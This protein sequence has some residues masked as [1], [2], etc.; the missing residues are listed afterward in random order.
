M[1]NNEFNPLVC[2]ECNF[3]KTPLNILEC[4]HVIC[5]D[6]QFKKKGRMFLIS[7][8][9]CSQITSLPL[10]ESLKSLALLVTREDLPLSSR[11]N[12]PSLLK[13]ISK[14]SE[15]VAMNETEKCELENEQE[16]L[17]VSYRLKLEDINLE[18]ERKL[19]LLEQERDTQITDLEKNNTLKQGNL[20]KQVENVNKSISKTIQRRNFL[21][22]C[23]NRL[24]ESEYNLYKSVLEPTKPKPRVASVSVKSLDPEPAPPLIVSKQQQFTQSLPLFNK[25]TV[26][27]KPKPKPRYTRNFSLCKDPSFSFGRY[28][29]GCME[30]RGL[31]AVCVSPDDS[32][33]FVLDQNQMKVF[34]RKGSFIFQ[35]TSFPTKRSNSLELAAIAADEINVYVTSSS[36][37][38]VYVI[39]LTYSVATDLQPSGSDL[40]TFI[41]ATGPVIQ[42]LNRP[43]PV[44]YNKFKS[45]LYIADNGNKRVVVYNAGLHYVCQIGKG[46]IELIGSLAVSADGELIYVLERGKI[47]NKCVRVFGYSGDLVKEFA[48]RHSELKHPWCLCV[49]DEGQVMISDGSP[50]Y[51]TLGHSVR[52]FSKEGKQTGKIGCSGKGMGQFKDPR[53]LVIDSKGNL[54]VIDSGNHRLQIF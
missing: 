7:C 17:A 47:S 36:H 29:T 37:D 20:S 46:Q 4:F 25:D 18:F 16:S 10:K 21:Q 34:D 45:L 30:F 39:S 33:V 41:G 35:F 11:G 13:N 53:G 32:C 40:K 19:R 27:A 50:D 54:I 43:G 8:P 12:I 26:P 31:K 28:G 23:S 14:L 42:R 52:V 2:V 1:A 51:G 49:S 48:M 3:S 6:C 24:P 15:E 38:I 5:H 22:T 44:E 9:S